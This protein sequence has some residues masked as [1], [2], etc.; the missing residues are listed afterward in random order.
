MNNNVVKFNRNFKNK[1]NSKTRAANGEEMEDMLYLESLIFTP[2]EF[3][4]YS[5]MSIISVKNAIIKGKIKTTICY[6]KEVIT[7]E[8]AENYF[9]KEKR[10]AQKL[11]TVLAVITC[12][13]L[14]ISAIIINIIN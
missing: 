8:E 13:I 2:E 6:G 14:I 7:Y 1:K 5:N 3:S 11:F 4:E 9:L 12:I 10:K